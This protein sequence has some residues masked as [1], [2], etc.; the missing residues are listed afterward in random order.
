MKAADRPSQRTRRLALWILVF[1]LGFSLIAAELFLRALAPLPDPYGRFKL[2]ASPK[3]ISRERPLK[4]SFP[5]EV[6]PGLPG[7][8]R[9]PRRFTTNNV[10]HRGGFLAR[11]KPASEY[12]VFMVGASTTECLYHD[13]SETVTFV[14][15]EEL[16]RRQAG[17]REWRVYG[18]GQ[19][20]DF[21]PDHLAVISQRVVHLEPDMIILFCGIND[22]SA[23]IFRLDYSFFPSAA[24][25]RKYSFRNLLTFVA[26]EFQLPRYLYSSLKKLRGESVREA[27]ETIRSRSNY[28]EKV[29]VRKR[30]P[31]ATKRPRTDLVSYEQNLRSIIGVARAHGIPLLFVTQ[32]STWNSRVDPKA[33]EWHWMTYREGVTYPPEWMD[34]ALEKYN[35]VMRRLSAENGTPVLDLARSMEKSLE[36]FYDDCHFNISGAQHAGEALASFVAERFAA[37]ARLPA[38][39]PGS[40][41]GPEAAGRQSRAR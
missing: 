26:T 17:R 36:F 39:L 28:R 21:S 12:R 14:L 3:P 38:A 16:R 34:E 11:P 24:T 1:S 25:T 37:R 22:L 41:P 6:E 20:G 31:V 8:P 4:F 2:V 9:R 35:D 7:M 19:S 18:A 40:G 32:P 13:D 30:A 10:G 27:L 15:Q 33:A 29:A 23:A 5:T